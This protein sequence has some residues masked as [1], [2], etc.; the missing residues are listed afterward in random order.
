V[1]AL[2]SETH[3]GRRVVKHLYLYQTVGHS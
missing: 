1:H 3:R 2:D